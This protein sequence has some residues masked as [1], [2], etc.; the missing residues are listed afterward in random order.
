MR[1]LVLLAGLSVAAVA[2]VGIASS[3][4]PCPPQSIHV[5]AGT[6]SN[7]FREESLG[8]NA[9]FG[10]V[11]VYETN[12][13]DCDGNGSSGD[14]DGDFDAG[15]GGAFL[16]SGPWANDP[17]CQNGFVAHHG[18]VVTLN[19]LV[20][21]SG[22]PFF[23][24]ADDTNGPVIVVD[25]TSGVQCTTDGVIAPQVDS[26]DCLAGVFYGSGTACGYGGDGG[27][28]VIV[29]CFATVGASSSFGCATSGTVTTF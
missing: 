3:Q 15:T 20:F 24:G 26:D 23:T 5:Y 16:P 18:P 9:G 28:W 27:Y 10:Y 12:T 22:V 13:A 29:A 1:T 19:D 7:E 17:I 25:P 6:G 11:Q 8:V 14:F 2:F 4:S 21:G